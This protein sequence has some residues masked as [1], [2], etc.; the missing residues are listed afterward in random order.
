MLMISFMRA[1]ILIK[2]EFATALVEELLKRDLIQ[3]KKINELSILSFLTE[4][5]VESQ[6]AYFQVVG[7]VTEELKKGT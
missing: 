2:Q 1:G 5:R 7:N 4:Y 3:E 6:K